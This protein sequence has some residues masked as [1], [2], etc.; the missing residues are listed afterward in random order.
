MLSCPQG[1]THP[2]CNSCK[3]STDRGCRAVPLPN[4]SKFTRLL[5]RKKLH[6]LEWEAAGETQTSSA[7][8]LTRISKPPVTSG[9]GN[10][11]FNKT[12]QLS[13]LTQPCQLL[14]VSKSPHLKG[15]DCRNWEWGFKVLDWRD[16]KC[17]SQDPEPLK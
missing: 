14:T 6:P 4:L 13:E 10:V 11:L 3:H 5:V 12:A 1:R 2:Q 9:V 8:Q 7:T 15:Q 16:G 17:L